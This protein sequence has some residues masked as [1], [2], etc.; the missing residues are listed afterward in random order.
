M[1]RLIRRH[2]AASGT[3]TCAKPAQ[4]GAD[5]AL[6][7]LSAERSPAGRRSVR[8]LIEATVQVSERSADTPSVRVLKTSEAAALLKREPQH[9][10]RL[11]APL[12][13]SQAPALSGPAP[14]F[15]YGEVAALRDALHEGLS[16]SSAVSRAREVPVHRQPLPRR[17]ARVLRARPGGRG[18]RGRA[19]AALA[20]AL[21]DGG[22]AA[23][24]RRDRRSPRNR[25]GGLGVRRRL[26]RGVAAAG[27]APGSVPG[28][29]G[30]DR[31]W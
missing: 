11:G 30:F 16:I 4:P 15:T 18:D 6:P 23:H 21:G 1:H 10:A 20:G 19:L 8:P 3:K 17:R 29:P 26:G 25:V 14:T 7:P 2:R 27:S 22:A 5:P 24:A 13:L 12:R 28:A 9:A 31:D